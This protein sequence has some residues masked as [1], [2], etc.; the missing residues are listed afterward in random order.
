MGWRYSFPKHDPPFEK[1]PNMSKKIFGKFWV[2]IGKQ[3]TMKK[4]VRLTESDLARI[5]RRVISER[6]FSPNVVK[7]DKGMRGGENPLRDR[8]IPESNFN[9]GDIV[10][11]NRYGKEGEVINVMFDHDNN[12]FIYQ[13]R[14]EL[15]GG[16]K[17]TAEFTDEE[18]S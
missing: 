15:P 11:I 16:K 12:N 7:Y 10:T 14:A 2:F 18:L 6:D 3:Y 5:V 13:V 9:E 17:Y 8:R 4:I 1:G